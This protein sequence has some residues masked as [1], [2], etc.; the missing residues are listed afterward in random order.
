[1][2][3]RCFM[4]KK[5]RQTKDISDKSW[6]NLLPA[7]LYYVRSSSGCTIPD[8]ILDH[9][10]PQ[11]AW[12]AKLQLNRKDYF[13]F[14]NNFSKRWSMGKALPELQSKDLQKATP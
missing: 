14:L 12:N 1:M 2:L 7:A 8:G 9:E 5:W 10:A 13:L 3:L 11:N 6:E 4:Q